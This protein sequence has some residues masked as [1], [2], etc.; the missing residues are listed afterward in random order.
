MPTRR[1]TLSGA[2]LPGLLHPQLDVRQTLSGINEELAVQEF[3]FRRGQFDRSRPAPRL[4]PN[5]FDPA[6]DR[7]W[8]DAYKKGRLSTGEAVQ[9][10]SHAASPSVPNY[11]WAPLINPWTQTPEY[12]NGFH[13]RS[14]VKDQLTSSLNSMRSLIIDVIERGGKTWRGAT[15]IYNWQG[16]IC[17]IP[18]PMV[19]ALS[20]F[21]ELQEW[22][23]RMLRDAATAKAGGR[24]HGYVS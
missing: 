6:C 11:D 1:Q 23:E 15:K 8:A 7:I 5:P 13:D 10:P 20:E 24:P 4:P 19:A 12:A 14:W 21:P 18:T 9:T 16:I 17:D 2:D 22:Y 3:G